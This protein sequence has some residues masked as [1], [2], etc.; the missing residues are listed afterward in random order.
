M[1]VKSVVINLPHKEALFSHGGKGKGSQLPA[2]S[3]L[4]RTF[5]R[6]NPQFS[7]VRFFSHKPRG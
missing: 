2:L 7:G 1:G 3:H 6:K 4:K 5:F